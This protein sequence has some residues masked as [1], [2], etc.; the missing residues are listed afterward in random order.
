[1]LDLLIHDAVVVDGT[2]REGVPGSVGIDAGHIVLV[3]TGS[4]GE[5]DRPAAGRTID[6]AGRV[7]AP[8]FIDVHTHSD[9]GSLVD[10]SMA[11]H[12]RQ[13]VT[14]IVVGNCGSSPWPTAGAA[15]CATMVGGDP[16][17][18]ELGFGSFGDYLERIERMRPALNVAA[19]VGQGAVRAEV[20]GY[21]RRPPTAEELVA[22]RRAVASAMADGAAGL[23]TGLIY[24]PGMHATTDEIV[25]LAAEAATA[26]GMYASH[27]RGEGQ[28]VFRAVAEAIEI[29][30]RAGL[31]AHVS[32]LKCEGRPAFGSAGA[33]L[34]S[35]DVADVTA[36][37][38]PYTAWSSNLWSLL[39]SW[40]PVGGLPELL[41]DT[42]QRSRVARAV[43]QGDEDEPIVPV[44][45]VGWDRI[46]IE[47]AA[48]PRWNGLSVAAIAERLGS[49]PVDGFFELLLA[50]PDTSCIGHAMSDEDVRTIASD[51]E[52]FVASDGWS[53]SPD[54]PLG[55][56]PVHPRNYGT[57]PRV[58][59]AFVREG[60]LTLEAAVRKM[61]S[62]PA[63]R[64]GLTGR[65][66]IAEGAWADLVL[67]DPERVADRGTFGD[68]HRFPQG[69]DL[70][71]VNGEVA[72]EAA[73]PT[74]TRRPGRVLR[75][76]QS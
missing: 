30:R 7:L 71:C 72:W 12:V 73:D 68:P 20:V 61:T 60:V 45:D 40:V 56:V 9:L 3:R 75:H 17:G 55:D 41:R 74:V 52:V 36:D 50:D 38:Y 57:F 27:I 14:T 8:G 49:E 32:H 21:E 6:A 10:P 11:S 1:V 37:Q 13:G 48:E 24:V 69:I 62:L 46:V 51:A 18:M 22:M 43:E 31:P 63:E 29:G 25:A 59:G 15:E 2:C 5:D 64:F 19:L 26:G 28:T 4:A 16:D 54:G 58:L 33:L 35:L 65:G 42:T 34:R 76:S 67:F 70:V 23:S 47:Q 39:P 44:N 53:M 66:R